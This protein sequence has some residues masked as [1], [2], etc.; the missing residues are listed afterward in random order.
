MLMQLIQSNDNVD[1]NTKSLNYM[2]IQLKPLV[3]FE[4]Q[5]TLKYQ[6]ELQ[7]LRIR[8]QLSSL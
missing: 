1:S 8:Q 2:K 4:L 5:Q 6:F 7:L 3:Y